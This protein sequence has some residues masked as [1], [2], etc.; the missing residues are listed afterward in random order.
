M[1]VCLEIRDD[2][3]VIKPATVS[4]GG[5]IGSHDGV[6]LLPGQVWRG[7]KYKRLRKLGAGE[8]ALAHKSNRLSDSGMG[9]LR[10]D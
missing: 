2:S 7:W 8:H 4:G 9:T 6:V 5:A 3:I 1:K 10:G